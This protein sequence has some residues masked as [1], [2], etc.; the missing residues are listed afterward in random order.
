MS[1]FD[2]IFGIIFYIINAFVYVISSIFSIVTLPQQMLDA[3]EL[4]FSMIAS[5]SFFLPVSTIGHFL[6][7]VFSFY[8]LQ[9]GFSIF[10]FVRS[11]IPI[12]RK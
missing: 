4:L 9:F 10:Q 11:F 3:F 6:I 7:V 2:I 8:L 5:V 12:I 1:L